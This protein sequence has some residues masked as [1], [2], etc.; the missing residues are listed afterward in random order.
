MPVSIMVLRCLVC[1]GAVAL[2]VSH[3][4]DAEEAFAAL[5][6]ARRR[7]NKLYSQIAKERPRV[8]DPP[9]T[10]SGGVLPFTDVPP[11][12]LPTCRT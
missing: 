9:K 5:K 12:C 11:H 7:M 8:A 1:W 4:V 3:P 10:S 6:E 2:S